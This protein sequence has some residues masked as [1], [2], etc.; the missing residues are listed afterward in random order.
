MSR[1]TLAAM[2]QIND[3]ATGEVL[4]IFTILSRT[5]FVP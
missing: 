5:D 1:P 4:R 3:A 2:L